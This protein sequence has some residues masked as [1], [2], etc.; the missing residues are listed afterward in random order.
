[1]TVVYILV[2]CQLPCESF[3]KANR[4]QRPVETGRKSRLLSSRNL[5]ESYLCKVL[6]SKIGTPDSYPAF[7]IALQVIPL[8]VVP[9]I[10]RTLNS[11]PTVIFT[12]TLKVRVSLNR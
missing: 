1:M 12:H 7:E 6:T 8:K 11:N 2:S 9:V 4:V 10:S 3:L 5:D